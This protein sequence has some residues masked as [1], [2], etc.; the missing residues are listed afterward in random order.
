VRPL[1]VIVVD[2]GSTDD[3]ERVARGLG[4]RVRYLRQANAG[5]AAARNAGIAAARGDCV[6]FLDSDDEWRPTKLEAQLAALS[7]APEAGWSLTGCEVIDL[8]GATVP[9]SGIADV[10]PAFRR[11]ELTP[12][13]FFARWLVRRPLEVR[14]QPLALYVGD[15]FLP[16]FYG[17]FGLPSSALVTRALLARAGG[18]DASFRFAEET[19]F[20]HRLAAQSPVAYL[21]EPLVGY[22]TSQDGSLV[23]P[24]NVPTLIGNALLS[25]DRARALRAGD[26]AVEEAHRAGR[27]HLLGELAY[28]RLTRFDRAGA[29]EAL[30]G[31]WSAGAP[32]SPRSLALYAVSHAPAWVLRSAHA[33]RRRLRW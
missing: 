16:W 11:S 30:R 22:R 9:G 24:A 23:S 6:A 4:D 25:L 32:R 29:R 14:G 26:P 1:E 10:F 15:A 3:T 8:T 7:A 31:A 21:V 18:F 17:N 27:R 5:V 2:D 19:E 12:G 13:A 28:D 33:L 20:F